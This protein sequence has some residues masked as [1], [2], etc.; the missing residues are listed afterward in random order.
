MKQKALLFL[1]F[2]LFGSQLFAQSG[3]SKQAVGNEPSLTSIT[4]LTDAAGQV[5][6]AWQ[7]VQ[8]SATMS[9]SGAQNAHTAFDAACASYLTAL[10][11]EATSHTGD[12]VVTGAIAREITLVKSLQS[13]SANK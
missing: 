12:S 9:R 13:G 10:Q 4:A 11:N 2:I 1:F 7:K 3:T 6:A 5:N 8:A